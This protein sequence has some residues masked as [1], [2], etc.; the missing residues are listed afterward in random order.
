[1]KTEISSRENPEPVPGATQFA[2]LVFLSAVDGYLRRRCGENMPLRITLHRI[3]TRDGFSYLQ[4]MCSYLSERPTDAAKV[5]RLNPVTEGIIGRAYSKKSVVRTRFYKD[6]KSL[7]A[8]LDKDRKDTNDDSPRAD[9]G[10]SYLAIP[11][12][13]QAG[14]VSTVFYGD[15]KAFNLFASDEI[16]KDIVGM[17]SGFCRAI[18]E[19]ISNPIGGFRNFPL[20][21]GEPVKET[22]TAYPRLQEEV[23]CGPLPTYRKITSF[24]FETRL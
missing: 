2:G 1:M 20:E 24:N 12:L 4:Q 10:T 17:C 8:D 16:V 19:I 23:D 13:N 14:E 3:M 22:P 15:A 18:D 5:G 21:F 11:M 6:Q 9:V 7:E